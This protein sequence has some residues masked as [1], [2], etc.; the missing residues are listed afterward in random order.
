M[1]KT[2]IVSNRLPI[3]LRHRNGRFEFKPSAGGLATGLGSIYKQGENIWIGWPGNTVDDPE[4]RA[5]IILELHDLKMAPVFLSKE[6]VEEFYEGFSNE[7]LWPAFHYFTQYMVYNPE[8]WEAYVRVN[9]KFCEA[10]LKKAGPDD[11]IW[12]HDYQLLLL[13]QM[14]RDVLPN[15]TIAFFQHIP[16]PSYEILRMIPWRKELL[17]GICGADL[18]GFH[19][20]DDMRHFLSA[21]G[22]ITGLSSESGYI[23]AENRI[24]NVD[25]FPMGIDYD[26][27]AKQ[28]KSK[29]TLRYVQ[30]F[31]QLVEGQKM[32]LTIDRLDYSKGIPQRIQ[33]FNQLLE[34]H[35]E[36]HG[37]VSMI[38]IVVPSRDKVQ[39]YKELK[40]EIDLLVG[41]IN[42]EY[43]T[44]NWVPVH[45][46]YRSFPFEELSAFYNMSDIALVTPL[47][48]G[49]NLVCKEFVASKTDQ[50]GV[51]ILSEMAGASKELQDAILVNPNDRQGV[52]DAIY[53]ALSMKPDEQ[54]A[55]MA[56]MQESL[57]K[58]DVFQWV[59]VFMDRVEHVK[60]K[61]AELTSKDVDAKVMNEIETSFK[62]A[63]KPILFLDYDGTLTGFT[64]DPQ[65]A[66]PDTELKGIIKSLSK[67]AQVVIIS[68]RDKDTL[69]KWFE[70]QHIDMIAEHGVWVKK[71]EDKGDWELYAEIEDNW[72]DDI[73]KVM[74]YYVLR[75]PGAFIE[76]KHHSLVWH[77]R[78][79]E[80]GLGDLRM[81]ELFSHLKYMA[82]GYNLQV[83]EG[84]MVLEIKRPDINKGRAASAIMKGE[85][86]DFILAIGDD[87]TDEDTF[88]AMPK[89][90]YSIRVGYAYTQANYNI[91]SFRQVRQL[92]HKLTQ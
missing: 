89:N 35:K 28:A 7:T 53:S 50:S 68:G 87:W 60:G 12:V 63:K 76:E 47:R 15:A 69:G 17:E 80:S 64:S 8:H 20:Y 88:K 11:T 29:K 67:K 38:M 77:Y 37:K 46:F 79:V 23:Q 10:I 1:S 3:S 90:A 51:L 14:L 56:S 57:K 45:Y 61:Q 33:A 85:E 81:R 54:Q 92:L 27:F 39:S 25:S 32:L 59:K 86:F 48:D 43:S 24:I 4:Q 49:M 18:I 40:E 36:L 55:R 2:I 74:E 78:K 82:R 19:T 75:T 21:V 44:L 6:D 83:L 71:K 13:P 30:Q 66:N 31:S 22:R 70:G 41:R 84:N 9:Q 16:F 52:V 62:K 42:S 72:K 73:R 91:K 65:K 58:Y 34:Q 26:K 5:E